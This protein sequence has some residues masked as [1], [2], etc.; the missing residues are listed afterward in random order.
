MD[1]EIK[2]EYWLV[3]SSADSGD[4]LGLKSVG[5]RTGSLWGM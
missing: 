4:V 1:R 5:S 3:T 2:E